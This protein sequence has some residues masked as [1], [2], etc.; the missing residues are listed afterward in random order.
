MKEKRKYVYLFLM[1]ILL[2]FIVT[3][4]KLQPSSPIVD[5]VKLVISFDNAS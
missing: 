2:I 3:A 4:C 1:L 5:K